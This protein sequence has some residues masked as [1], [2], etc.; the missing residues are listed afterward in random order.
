MNSLLNALK[1]EASL[2]DALIG[3]CREKRDALV[4]LRHAD[5]DALVAREE[6]LLMRISD[7]DRA[8]RRAASDVA[9][10]LGLAPAAGLRD[11]ARAGKSGEL[12]GLRDR[13]A[14][15]LASLARANDL[16]R[17]L[18]EQSLGHVQEF[19]RALTG[20][21]ADGRYSRRGKEAPGKGGVVNIVDSVA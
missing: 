11:I 9:A 17:A 3:V 4:A 12:M 21:Q 7:A 19:F 6:A 16:N 10:T 20:A 2:Y 13:L 14:G 15:L 5:L 18:A 8:R 1:E